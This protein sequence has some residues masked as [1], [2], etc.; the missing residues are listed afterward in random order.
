LWARLPE[1]GYDLT[2]LPRASVAERADF[3]LAWAELDE[4]GG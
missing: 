1:L 4:P 2:E 3:A